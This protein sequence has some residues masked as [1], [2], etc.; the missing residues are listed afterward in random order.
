M[1]VRPPGAFGE[2]FGIDV[3]PRKSRYT[4]WKMEK[5]YQELADI[6][7][8]DEVHP[9]QEL[10]GFEAWDSLAA[11]SLVAFVRSSFDVTL[12]SEDL[13]RATTVADL[14][15]LVRSKR[16]SANPS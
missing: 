14:E 3:F 12:T 8:V 5:L 9:D 15:Q 7:E 11:L 6:L 1:A 13:R 10:H 16:Q 2:P 4:E